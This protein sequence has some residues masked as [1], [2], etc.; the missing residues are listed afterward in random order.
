[1]W[2][3]LLSALGPLL[4]AARS[5]LIV[6]LGSTPLPAAELVLTAAGGLAALPAAAV[7]PGGPSLAQ[8]IAAIARPTASQRRVTAKIR[9]WF[10]LAKN[11]WVMA[12]TSF[13]KTASDCNLPFV[14]EP[15]ERECR[16]AP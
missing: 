11:G 3:A 6:A 16:C 7:L 10:G 13:T 1:M 4:L 8:P 5:A 12:T 2:P 9:E 14:C 15:S